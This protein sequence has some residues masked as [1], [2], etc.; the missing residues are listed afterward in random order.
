VGMLP[1]SL[2]FSRTF[3]GILAFFTDCAMYIKGTIDISHTIAS[4]FQLQMMQDLVD[5][6][7]STGTPIP[8]LAAKQILQAHDRLLAATAEPPE[9]AKRFHRTFRRS[10]KGSPLAK[11]SECQEQRAQVQRR[12]SS[13]PKRRGSESSCAE[14]GVSSTGRASTASDRAGSG[15]NALGTGHDHRA[16]EGAQ[17]AARRGEYLPGAPGDGRKSMKVKRQVLSDEQMSR[18]QVWAHDLAA[19]VRPMLSKKCSYHAVTLI[20]E[21]IRDDWLP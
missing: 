17:A 1:M 14:E 10:S 3:L 13:L 8:E 9:A 7:I 15:T 2:R 21:A 12:R 6:I 5:G 18:F 4:V 19:A 16:A 20:W 11:G